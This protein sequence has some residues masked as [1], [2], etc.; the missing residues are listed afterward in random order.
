MNKKINPFERKTAADQEEFK[1]HEV[2]FELEKLQ[3]FY[4]LFSLSIMNFMTVG[5]RSIINIDSYLYSSIQGTL[6]SI[7]MI[8]KKGRLGD[9]FSLLRKYHDSV[10]LNVYTNIYLANNHDLSTRLIVEE[11]TDWLNG[12]K[13]LPHN[14]YGSMSEYIERS[15]K[16]KDI[17]SILSKDKSY[18]LTRQRCNDHTHYNYFSNVLVNDNQVHFPKRIELLNTFKGDLGNIALLHLSCIFKL[19]DHYMMSSDYIDYLEM[20]MTPESNSQYWVAPFVQSVFTELIEKY[21]PEIA[22]L[23]KKE[24]SMK[25]S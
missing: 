7:G 18:R 12:K 19:N 21:Q 20:G 14:T 22:K 10:I 16:L 17:F 11:I 24:S 5:T 15:E 23:I 1:S 25:L 3:S 6:E 9:A 4:D 8:L 13:K 2:F